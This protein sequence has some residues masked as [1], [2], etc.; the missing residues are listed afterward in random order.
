MPELAA[1]HGC[2]YSRVRSPGTFSNRE[3]P[4]QYT[5]SF[6][7]QTTHTATTRLFVW[8]LVRDLLERH[9]RLLHALKA[10]DPP[11]NNSYICQAVP[12]TATFE[13]GAP[14]R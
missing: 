4:R 6:I 9:A 8:P 2:S 11:D 1:T 13:V 12:L 10:Q 3:T 5:H 7:L 14:F